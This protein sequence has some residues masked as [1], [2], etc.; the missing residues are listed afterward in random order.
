MIDGLWLVFS[1]RDAVGI[2]CCICRF[3]IDWLFSNVIIFVIFKKKKLTNASKPC[4]HPRVRG[5]K[6][7]NVQVGS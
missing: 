2:V 1:C 4:E 3:M 5:K 6:I 7:Q